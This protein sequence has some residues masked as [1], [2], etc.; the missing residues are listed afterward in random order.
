ME[1]NTCCNAAALL[2]LLEQ[3]REFYSSVAL[4]GLDTSRAPANVYLLHTLSAIEEYRAAF[5]DA[6]PAAINDDQLLSLKYF[7][8]HLKR[9]APTETM[10]PETLRKEA[11]HLTQDA[12]LLLTE[13][14][15]GSRDPHCQ[16]VL[17]GLLDRKKKFLVSLL[18]EKTINAQQSL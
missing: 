6:K 18:D 9:G 7:R 3:C 13:L 5:P 1:E 16:Q 10:D 15:S 14:W 8:E 12:V 4:K 2:T 11:L 17:H